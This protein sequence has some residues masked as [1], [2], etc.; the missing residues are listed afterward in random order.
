MDGTTTTLSAMKL[1][2]SKLGEIN[3]QFQFTGYSHDLYFIP[4]ACHMIQTSNRCT[5][6]CYHGS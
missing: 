4:D 2:E 1:C 6:L 3:G 5:F